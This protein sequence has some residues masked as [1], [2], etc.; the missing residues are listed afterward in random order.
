MNL[1]PNFQPFKEYFEYLNATSLKSLIIFYYIRVNVDNIE[2][3]KDCDSYHSKQ[4]I[5]GNYIE[6]IY[7][8]TFEHVSF[9]SGTKVV[10]KITEEYLYNLLAVLTEE[11]IKLGFANLR[12]TN[13]LRC[14]Y[15]TIK[16]K[17]G[18]AQ[19]KVL[20]SDFK[21]YCGLYEAIKEFDKS[22]KLDKILILECNF[23]QPT[24][25]LVAK[26]ISTGE[27]NKPRDFEQAIKYI[28]LLKYLLINV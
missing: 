13:P 20:R 8:K 19:F 15:L 22:Y 21:K 10:T 12:V 27:F 18:N 14:N 1:P 26:T 4:Y 6:R 9:R 7:L 24:A 28:D 3:I 2:Y 16:S 25:K 11:Q 5:G 23:D 17:Y